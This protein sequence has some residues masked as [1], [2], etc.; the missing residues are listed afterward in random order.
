MHVSLAHLI[1]ADLS[2]NSYSSNLE[3]TIIDVAPRK[4]RTYQFHNEDQITQFIDDLLQQ[5]GIP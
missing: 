1:H 3:L 5:H 2:F 4:H